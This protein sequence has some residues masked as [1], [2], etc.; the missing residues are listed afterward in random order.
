MN[1]SKDSAPLLIVMGQS[2]AHA[3]GTV[4]PSEQRILTPLKNVHGLAC[5]D[6]Q[7]YGLSDVKWSGFVSHDMNLGETQNHTCCLA[8][9]FA[10]MWQDAIDSGKDLPDLYIIQISVGGQGIA[11]F[12][13]TEYTPIANMWYPLR[14]PV[15]K[16]GRGNECDISLYPLAVEI[17]SLSVMNLMMAGKKPQIIGLHFNQYETECITGSN[18][19]NHAEENYENLFWGFFTALGSDKTGKNVPLRL[20]RP[21]TEAIG[22][23]PIPKDRTDRINEIFEGF[24]KK[25]SNC[26]II[27]LRETALWTD[28]APRHGIFRFDGIHYTPEAHFEFAKY[29]WRELFGDN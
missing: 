23:V 17:L 2:N 5:E 3:H 28:E 13:M 27:D 18:A 22:K 24:T 20:Y 16:P 7:A 19:L 14:K 11:E 9:Y 8:N 21:L 15:L 12:E 26:K 10:K 6:N 29:Q 1:F 4:L 25:Y